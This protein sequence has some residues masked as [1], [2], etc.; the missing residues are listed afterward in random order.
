MKTNYK[1]AAMWDPGKIVLSQNEV[2][3]VLEWLYL[4]VP[5]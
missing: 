1:K 5:F 2:N 4:L 3:G